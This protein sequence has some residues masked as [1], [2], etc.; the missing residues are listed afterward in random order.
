MIERVTKLPSLDAQ[1][2]RT[3]LE[4][5]RHLNSD[6]CMAEIHLMFVADFPELTISYSKSKDIVNENCRVPSGSARSDICECCEK[7]NVKSVAQTAPSLTLLSKSRSRQFD[8][9][10]MPT[11]P[12]FWPRQFGRNPFGH[13]SLA[14]R[15]F[16][17]RAFWPP[18]YLATRL[19]GHRAVWPP[20]YLATGLF[21]RP[22]VLFSFLRFRFSEISSVGNY[23]AGGIPPRTFCRRSL[24]LDMS[25]FCFL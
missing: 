13:R 24:E 20:G 12:A 16:N 18:G 19:F 6:L 8:R 15:F 23:P 3:T 5:R 11:E 21:G 4:V 25:L 7:I 22:R 1:Y 10:V 14:T 17:H 9:G 2:S